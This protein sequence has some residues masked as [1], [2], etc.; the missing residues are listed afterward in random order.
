MCGAA[1]GR[2]RAVRLSGAPCLQRIST[3]S[4]VLSVFRPGTPRVR[5]SISS[6]CEEEPVDEVVEEEAGFPPE[7][8]ASARV[9]VPLV[10]ATAPRGEMRVLAG[11]PRGSAERVALVVER[12]GMDA[13]AAVVFSSTRADAA[14][15]WLP[16]KKLSVYSVIRVNNRQGVIE[17]D[18]RTH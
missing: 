4:P 12:G 3:W 5:G 6:A 18:K 8:F 1:G 7:I 14:P 15:S 13:N 11:D 2:R 10:G 9:V 16:V 17:C